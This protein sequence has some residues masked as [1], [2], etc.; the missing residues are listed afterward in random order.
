MKNLLAEAEAAFRGGKIDEAE[1]M[2]RRVVASEPESA[3]AN[4]MLGLI[5]LSRGRHAD[6]L[7]EIS[8]AVAANPLRRATARPSP[9][10]PSCRWP[11]SISPAC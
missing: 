9:S 11:W 1:A 7:A 8:R 5:A 6:A 10:I 4:H 3:A 2:L